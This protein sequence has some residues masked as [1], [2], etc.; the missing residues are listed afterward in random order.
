MEY[1]NYIRPH[2][3]T[4]KDSRFNPFALTENYK[5]VDYIWF[6]SVWFNQIYSSKRLISY[7][8]GPVIEEEL[9]YLYTC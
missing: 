5:F 1:S 9:T 7:D 3:V 2:S 8:F 4:T 6:P